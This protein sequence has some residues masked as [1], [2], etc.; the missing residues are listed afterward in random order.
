MSDQLKR[1]LGGMTLNERLFVTGLLDE[2]ERAARARERKA[3][4]RLL[5][6]VEFTRRNAEPTVEMILADTKFH[7]F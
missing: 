4:I 1:D 5:E 6:R 7:G 3:M 2:F